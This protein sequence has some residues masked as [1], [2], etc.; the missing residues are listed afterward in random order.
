MSRLEITLKSDL[1]AASGDGFSSVIDTDVSFQREGFPVI[2]GRRLKGCL[3]LA[4][5]RIGAEHIAEIFGVPG[6]SKPGVLRISDA[7]VVGYDDLKHEAKS[8][9]I[10]AEKMISLFTYTRANT[11]IENDTA[12]E[13][14]LRFMRVVR[15]Y[16]PFSEEEL[17]FYADVEIAPAYQEEFA[18]ICR[19]LRNIGYKRNRGFGA[20]SCNF[21]YK[22]QIENITPGTEEHS[23]E[24]RQY[25][26]TVCLQENVMIPGSVSDETLDYIPGTSVLGFLA[27]RYL[28]VFGKDAD[29]EEIFLKNQ[30]RCSNLYFSDENGKEYFPAPVILG[31]IKGEKGVV[32]MLTYENPDNEKIIKPVKSGFCD[33]GCNI[34][35]PLTETVYHH[36]AGDNSTLYTQNSL[37]SGQYFRGTITGNA[38]YVSKLQM[39][40]ESAALRFGRSKTAQYSNC[41]LV[42]GENSSFASEEISIPKGTEFMA[43]LLSD[44]FIPDGAAG[45]DISV[46][47]LKKALGLGQLKENRCSALRYRVISGYHTKWNMQKPHVRT[48]AAGS[49]LIFKS[50]EDMILKKRLFI[51][52]RQN[53]GFGQVMFCSC[54]EFVPV[55][56]SEDIQ[57]TEGQPGTLSA[58]IKEK[59]AR[60]EMRQEALKFFDSHQNDMK[61]NAQTGRYLLMVKAAEDLDTLKLW[62]ESIKSGASKECLLQA[63]ESAE[64]YREDFWRE[65]L[66]LLFTLL[67]YAERRSQS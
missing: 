56:K 20:V 55:E 40:L 37:C 34:R 2:G 36:S 28:S 4:A 10:P 46:D 57:K 45:Y 18:E 7:N 39:L 50:E 63:I 15:Q 62:A 67:K 31:K 17:K 60:E 6:S 48:I 65:Y 30:V 14:S 41:V 47:G 42:K 66:T 61:N 24:I 49:T 29:F 26:Y 59:Q 33:F 43:L 54:K 23:Q 25:A 58:W 9:R 27:G 52:A 32:N 64:A 11:A 5:E 22:E 1:C 19:A 8:M 13:N 21:L 53:E 16:S 51:G 12:K 38:V 35:K 3:R 44:V